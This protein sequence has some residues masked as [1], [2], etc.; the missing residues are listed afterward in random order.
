MELLAD[1]RPHQQ[2][3][4]WILSNGR[5]RTRC[6]R[7]CQGI[8]NDGKYR[9]SSLVPQPERSGGTPTTFA[10]GVLM[11]Y[12]PMTEFVF[13]FTRPLPEGREQLSRIR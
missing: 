1:S 10:G 2:A 6:L 4:P 3:Q 11:F 8:G 5:K 13:H 12:F 7:N 9:L